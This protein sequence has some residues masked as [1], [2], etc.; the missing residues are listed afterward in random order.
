MQNWFS[1]HFNLIPKESILQLILNWFQKKDSESRIDS[2][3]IFCNWVMLQSAIS[4]IYS[5]SIL[6]VISSELIPGYF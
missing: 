2:E 1:D 4:W 5:E 3:L 6:D